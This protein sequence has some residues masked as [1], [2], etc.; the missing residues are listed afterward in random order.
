M[1]IRSEYRALIEAVQESERLVSRQAYLVDDFRKQLHP[2]EAR[3]AD[4]QLEHQSRVV[5]LND[6][7]KANFDR[8]LDE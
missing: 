2:E 7:E 6:F 1:S 3:L 4:L 8:S 5:A